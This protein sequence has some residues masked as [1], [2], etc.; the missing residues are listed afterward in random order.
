[1]DR[2]EVIAGILLVI[3]LAGLPAGVEAEGADDW[4]VAPDL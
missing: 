1:M 3:V 2:M 4:L